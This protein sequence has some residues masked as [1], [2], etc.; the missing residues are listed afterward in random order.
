MNV[1]QKITDNITPPNTDLEILKKNF[2]N[3]FD[4]NG[5]FDFEKF[6]TQLAANEINFSKESYGM[7]WLGKSYA[8]LLA[9]DETTSLLKEDEE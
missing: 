2:P 5:A 6:K 7:D 8:R 3:C 1:E 4:K 9:T